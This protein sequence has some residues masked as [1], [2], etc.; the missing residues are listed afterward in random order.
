MKTYIYKLK[1]EDGYFLV[2]RWEA[3]TPEEATPEVVCGAP[4]LGLA[5]EIMNALSSVKLW[6]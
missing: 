5:L 1:P 6:T 2:Y 4:T 3:N